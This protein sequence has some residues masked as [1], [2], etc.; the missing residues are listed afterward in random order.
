MKVPKYKELFPTV[1]RMNAEQKR[2]YRFW[3]SEWCSGNAIPLDGQVSYAFCYLYSALGLP[4][5]K[6]ARV[7]ERMYS[8]Y[9]DEETLTSQVRPWLSDCYVVEGKYVAAL[10]VLPEPTL[11]GR[12]S[13]GTDKRLNLKLL[14]GN[15]ISGREALALLGLKVSEFDPTT[16]QPVSEYLDIQL[17]ALEADERTNLLEVWASNAYKTR[18]EIFSGY[19]GA[20]EIDLPFY[21]FSTHEQAL[22]EISVLTREAEKTVREDEAATEASEVWAAETEL[23]YRLK[24]FFSQEPVIHHFRPAWLG[25][26]HLDIV[27]PRRGVAIEYR[28]G[29]QNQPG[30][31]SE[32]ETALNW[33]QPHDTE[34]K[35]LCVAHSVRLVEVT[36]GYNFDSLLSKIILESNRTARP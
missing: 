26:Q 27:L 1:D 28:G 6:A 5:K 7:L 21:H 14:T 12:V 35:S 2:F 25:H 31:L 30:G 19:L 23:F 9:P 20:T 4:A 16:L 8:A 15:R 24:K 34:K 13:R 32:Y 3:L 10:E 33:N 11:N 36:P 18:Y 22:R 17:R 29:K